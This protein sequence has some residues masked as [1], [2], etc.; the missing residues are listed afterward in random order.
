M[1]GPNNL[2]LEKKGFIKDFLRA[3][4]MQTMHLCMLQILS[5]NCMY[6]YW[7]YGVLNLTL[8]L[9]SLSWQAWL[10]RTAQAEMLELAHRSTMVRVL[11]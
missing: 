9:Y 2:Q 3:E 5:L 10:K 7:Q 1:L 8:M 6:W 11:R 4:L